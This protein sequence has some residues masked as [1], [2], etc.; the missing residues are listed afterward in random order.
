MPKT[1]LIVVPVAAYRLGPG[2]F[3]IEGPF[4]AH[5]HLLREKLGSLGADMVLAAPYM[6]EHAYVTQ[7]HLLTVV[8]EA[9]DGI[10]FNGM[11]PAQSGTREFYRGIVG[12]Y[13]AMKKEVEAADVVHAG[14][15]PLSRPF[16]FLA[17]LLGCKLGK[18][19]ISVTDIDH[20]ESAHMNYAT[21]RWSLKEYLVTK[22]LHDSIRHLQHVFAV[23]CCSL[24]ILKGSQMALDYGKKRSNVKY[25]LD[26]AFSEGH[27]IPD[28]QLQDKANSL[29]DLSNPVQLA[30]FG[31]LV[32]YKGIAHMLCAVQHAIGRGAH[33]R[34]HIIGDG[35]QRADLEKLSRNLGLGRAVAFHGAIPF[36]PQLF[37]QLYRMHILLAA[38]L[39]Q[40]TPRSALDAMAS[41]QTV[42]AYDTYY[43]RELALAGAPVVVVP[44]LA[45]D[46]LGQK[47]ADT[48]ADRS[49]LVS[50]MEQ[51]VQFAQQNTQ[52][53][54]LNRRIDWTRAVVANASADRA[55]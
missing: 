50:N 48:V 8:D 55:A 31:R 5:L 40:D 53:I 41:A 17:L 4:A 23:R 12:L 9:R 36:G 44:W 7:K 34:F 32:E 28:T 46:A 13:K 43:Y 45:K 47:I 20:R 27:I 30:Y 11:Y 52:E 26:S 29:K 38:P 37:D 2:Q 21:G 42:I 33:V 22:V 6:C 1:Y 35:P 51:A 16:E 24:V 15:S 14:P 25:I 3:A 49:T 39:S 18:T 54:W 19:T 10:R